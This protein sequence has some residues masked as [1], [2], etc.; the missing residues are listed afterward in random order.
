MPTLPD[1]RPSR[2]DVAIA[3][4]PHA[5]L[6]LLL[7]SKFQVPRREFHDRERRGTADHGLLKANALVARNTSGDAND[8]AQRLRLKHVEG[9]IAAGKDDGYCVARHL[10]D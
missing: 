9:L 7:D 6:L 4:R 3:R 1:V 5:T 8:H 10:A 2:A